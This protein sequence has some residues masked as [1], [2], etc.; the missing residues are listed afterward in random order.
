M[1]RI[2]GNDSKSSNH[3]RRIFITPLFIQDFQNDPIP[4]VIARVWFDNMV[5]RTIVQRNN[6]RVA[7]AGRQPGQRCC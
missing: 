1:S 4:S 7:D 5:A 3:S 2:E 6:L